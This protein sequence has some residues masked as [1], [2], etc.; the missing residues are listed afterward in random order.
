[1]SDSSTCPV[2]EFG[3]KRVPVTLFHRYVVPERQVQHCYYVTGDADFVL[4]FNVADMGEYETLTRQLFF[5]GGNVNR[6]TTLVAM[7]T[8]KANQDVLVDPDDHG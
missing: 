3:N 2:I 8:I 5:E 7:D 1:M 6:F 4:V